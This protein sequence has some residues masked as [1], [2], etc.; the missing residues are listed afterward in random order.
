MVS[1]EIQLYTS[2]ALVLVPNFPRL[3]EIVSILYKI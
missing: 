1:T 2:I 3:L